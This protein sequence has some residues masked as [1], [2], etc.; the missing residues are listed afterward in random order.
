MPMPAQVLH[1]AETPLICGQEII[2]R[3]ALV[4]CLPSRLVQISHAFV[5]TYAIVMIRQQTIAHFIESMT[6]FVGTNF[7]RHGFY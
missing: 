4:E 6:S 7:G 3:H 2:F 5:L 1:S